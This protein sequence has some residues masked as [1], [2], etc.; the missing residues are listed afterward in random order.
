MNKRQV[1]PEHVRR[2][3][4][5]N[6]AYDVI[7]EVG[8]SNTTIA[9][10][11]KKA[12]LSVGIVSHYF[13]DKQGLI[14]ACMLEMLNV[15]RGKTAQYKAELSDSDPQNMIKAII[16]SNFDISQVNQRAMRIWLDFWSASM[17]M[18]ELGRLQRIND[19]RLYSNLKFHFLKLLPEDQASIAA[20]GLAALIDGLWLRGSLNGDTEFDATM[21]R[22]IAYDY[23]DT[24]LKLMKHT[25]QERQNE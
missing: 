23:V 7:Y 4:I 14:N 10:I 11:A 22:S 15:L 3:E 9:Q 6:A 24:Q 17:H 2:E 18:P 5:I 13:G 8:L 1:K 25:R 19:Q 20:R 21:A 16:D 12:Q